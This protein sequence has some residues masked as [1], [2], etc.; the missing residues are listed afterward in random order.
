MYAFSD[1]KITSYYYFKITIFLYIFFSKVKQRK[2][3]YFNV[4][5]NNY[6]FLKKMLKVISKLSFSSAISKMIQSN[7]KCM[8]NSKVLYSSFV[9]GS[10]VFNKK[11]DF[12]V[13][14]ISILKAN[15]LKKQNNNEFSFPL[16]SFSTK[17]KLKQPEEKKEPQKA[18][19]KAIFNFLYPYY[20]TPYAKTIMFIAI[21]LT[22][23]SK[24]LSTSVRIFI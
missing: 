17:R 7:L 23:I 9:S 11:T 12:K 6:L 14:K 1:S 2:F 21:C 15:N 22:T 5:N 18:S 3:S 20:S 8:N 13:N 16:F 4:L 10:P 19:L 24:T